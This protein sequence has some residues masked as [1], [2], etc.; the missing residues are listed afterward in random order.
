VLQI[1]NVPGESTVG[2]LAAAAQL[3]GFHTMQLPDRPNPYIPIADVEFLKKMPLNARLRT[4]LRQVRRQLSEC[5]SADFRRI[6]TYDRDSL[7]RFYQLEAS[8]WKGE[9]GTAIL[10]NGTQ[11]FYDEIAKSAAHFGY[12]SLYLLELKGELIAA[13][14]SLT[15]RDKCYS[16]IVTYNEK[17]SQYAPGHLIVSEILQDCVKRGIRG[18]DITGQDQPWKMKWTTEARPVDHHFI[19][20]GGM[21]NLAYAFESKL[22][23]AVDRLLSGRRRIA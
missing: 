5:G 16:P 4:K 7:D 3:D 11:V 2:Q 19:F 14:F 21:G 8:G 12:F 22:K 10:R 9:E 1:S 18:F 23:P 13:H 15:Y 17:F 20:R 6:G